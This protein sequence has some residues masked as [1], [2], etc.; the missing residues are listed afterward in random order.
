ML[1]AQQRLESQAPLVI[2]RPLV[3]SIPTGSYMLICEK[4]Y[5]TDPSIRC[6]AEVTKAR[7]WMLMKLKRTV[8]YSQ[9]WN[10]N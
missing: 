1:A 3:Q 2:G 5:H 8:L 10:N 9:G 7:D 6:F 4:Y